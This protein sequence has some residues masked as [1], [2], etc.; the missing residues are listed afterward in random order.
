MKRTDLPIEEYLSDEW[1]NSSEVR[2]LPLSTA[3]AIGLGI[4][5][6]VVLVVAAV[7]MV[8]L[9]QGYEAFSARALANLTARETIPAPRGLILDRN[10][11]VL[12]DNEPSF[13]LFLDLEKFLQ[14]DQRTRQ[15]ILSLL[16]KEGIIDNDFP[17]YKGDFSSIKERKK[18]LLASGLQ[19]QQVIRLSSQL[20]DIVSFEYGFHRV[21]PLAPLFASILGYTGM[22]RKSDL[23]QNPHLDTRDVIGY[24]GIEAVYDSDLRGTPG[25]RE[26]LRDARGTKLAKEKITPPKVGKTIQLTI[27]AEFQEFFWKRLK[28]RLHALGSKVGVGIAM[29]PQNGEVLALFQIPEF[30]NNAFVAPEK[31]AARKQILEN[32]LSPLFNRAVGGLYNP[33]ST[34]KPLV[35]V[36]AL[37]DHII[38]PKETIFSPGYL[39]VPNPYD[40]Q[41]PSRFLDWRYQ[42]NVNLYSAIAKSSNVYFYVVGG[43]T[44][45]RKGLGIV[46][47]RKWWQ[48]FGLGEKTG[49]DLPGEAEGLLPSPDYFQKKGKQWRLGDT[50]NVSIGQGALLVTPLQILNYISAIANGGTLYVPHLRHDP[51]KFPKILRDLT[52]YHD[53]IKE[54]QKGMEHTVRSPEGTAY[55]L[56]DLPFTVAAKTGSAQVKHRTQENAFFVGYAPAEN[57]QIAILV[58]IENSKEGSAN[59]IP[60]AYDVLQWY[61]EHRI[62]APPPAA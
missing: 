62:A 56:H 13:L 46:R 22:V 48:R 9:A 2:E 51:Q 21:Y 28:K 45:R 30:D 40:P 10:N 1:A 19:Q 50:Y 52:S 18:L 31:L 7:R 25:T 11:V 38:T 23:D 17:F 55:L 8:A 33:G 41:R 32:P 43:G 5:V 4:C 54:V 29:N 26:T 6:S 49:I 35:G 39:E 47:L 15:H 37:H 60:V 42:G 16:Q 53:E 3:S 20:R 61:Y 12:A 59:T 14:Q 36:A 58:L 34:V 57:P 44:K 27:D 24:T